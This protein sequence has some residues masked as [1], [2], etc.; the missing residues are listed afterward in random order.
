MSGEKEKKKTR[1]RVRQEKNKQKYK[2]NKK[3]GK[4]TGLFIILKHPTI[5]DSIS[6]YVRGLA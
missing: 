5:R 2:I 1:R 3:T 4:Q 6:R